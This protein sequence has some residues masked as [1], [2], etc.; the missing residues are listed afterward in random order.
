[1]LKNCNVYIIAVP[2][3]IDE[4]KKVNLNHLYSVNKTL[5]KYIEPNNIIMLES[6]I[7]VGGTREIFKDFLKQNVYVGFSPERISPGDHENGNVIPKLISG[8]NK[9]SLDNI[10]PLNQ[11]LKRL[12]QYLHQKLLKCVNYMKIVL[13]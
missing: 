10:L 13:G 5:K 6:S 2:T 7:Y 11:F 12:S 8:L 1:M 3:N 4:N 9:P